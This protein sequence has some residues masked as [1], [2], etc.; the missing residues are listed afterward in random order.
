MREAKASVLA[1]EAQKTLLLDKGE[2]LEA[3]RQAGIA[4]VGWSNGE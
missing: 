4:V 2:L 1:V 3:A